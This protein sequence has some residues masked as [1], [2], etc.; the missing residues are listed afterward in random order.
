[1]STPKFYV[2]GMNIVGNPY[3]TSLTFLLASEG[4]EAEPQVTLM[5]SHRFLEDVYLAL[6]QIKDQAQKKSDEAEATGEA[7]EPEED[8]D[9]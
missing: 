7:K 4:E 2:N 3:E 5:M 8:L 9:E 6:K 1:M